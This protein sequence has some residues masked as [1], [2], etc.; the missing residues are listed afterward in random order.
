MT[1]ELLPS[2]TVYL[3]L[4]EAQ[5]LS[6]AIATQASIGVPVPPASHSH[7]IDLQDLQLHRIL[8]DERNANLPRCGY[9]RD[10]KASATL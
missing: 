6:A 10:V 5:L 8:N 4:H 9:A 1:H 3:T 7:E 2:I